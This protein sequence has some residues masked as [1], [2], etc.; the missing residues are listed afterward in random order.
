MRLA[1]PNGVGSTDTFDT[2]ERVELWFQAGEALSI[3]TAVMVNLL[4]SDAGKKVVLATTANDHNICGFFE[5]VGT[6]LKGAVNAVTGLKGRAAASGDVILVTCY[7]Y[8]VGRLDTVAAATAGDPLKISTAT[9]GLL[10]AT[11]TSSVWAGLVAPIVLLGTATNAA[12]A[13]ATGT[14]TCSVWVHLL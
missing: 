9:A 10:M 8:V 2:A 4:A 14:A 5:G 12:T 6:E 7:G 3:G 13:T 1:F 11:A